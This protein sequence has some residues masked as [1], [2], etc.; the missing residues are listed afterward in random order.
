M[1]APPV[2]F[3]RQARNPPTSS[4]RWFSAVCHGNRSGQREAPR[5]DFAQPAAGRIGGA[6]VRRGVSRWACPARG[7][8]H[9]VPASAARDSPRAGR[10]AAG[11]ASLRSFGPPFGRPVH[12]HASV[13]AGLQYFRWRSLRFPHDATYALGRAS[14]GVRFGIHTFHGEPIAD[15]LLGLLVQEV[16]VAPF[17]TSS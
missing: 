16:D 4:R 9:R 7:Q 13:T 12:S 8:A 1:T 5:G 15:I 6:G 3:S 2:G 14:G 11:S 17:Q 10:A